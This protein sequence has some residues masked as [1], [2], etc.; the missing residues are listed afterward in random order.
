MLKVGV[1]GNNVTGAI[2]ECEIDPRLQSCTLSEVNWMPQNI[3]TGS[4]CSND[5]Q[6][7]GAIINHGNVRVQ[8]T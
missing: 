1:K 6:I 8:P 2:L 7:R 5:R 4:A 3:G